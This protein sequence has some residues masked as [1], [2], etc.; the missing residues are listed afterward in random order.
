MFDERVTRGKR[1]HC[2]KCGARRID[3]QIGLEETPDAYVAKLVEVFREV[4]RILHP[5]GTVWLNLGDSFANDGK[6]GGQ[7]GGLNVSSGAERTRRNT[8]LKPKDLIGIPWSVAF[9]LRADGWWLRQEIIWCLSGGTW[10]Y[11]KTQKGEM[12]MMIGDM[13]RLDPSTVKL[14]NGEK[15][16]QV[17]GWSRSVRNDDELELVLRSGERISCTPNHQWPTTRGLLRAD[18]LMVGDYL[19]SCRLPESSDIHA[20]EAIP[21]E[22]AWFLGMYLAEGSRSGSAI[23]IAGHMREVERIERLRAIAEYYGGSLTYKIHGN[24]LTIRMYGGLLHALVDQYIGGDNAKTKGLKVRCWQHSN[25]WLKSLLA[26]YL[27]GDGHWDESNKRWR[28]GFTRNYNLERDLR[29]MCARLGLSLT[30]KLSTATY[31]GGELPAFRGEIRM[32]VSDHHNNKPRTEIVEIRKAR[33][34]E[35][36]DIGVEDEPHLFALASGILTHNSKKAPMPESVTDRPT[37]AHE[38]VFLLSKQAN[39]FYDAE[40]IREPIARE[41][42][43]NSSAGYHNGTAKQ[44]DERGAGLSRKAF[45]GN[46][47]DKSGANRRSVWSLGPENFA[48]AHFAVMPTKLVEPCILAGTSA[49][50]CCAACGAPWERVVERSKYEPEEVA[51]G[52]RNVDDSRGDKTR[53]LS[54]KADNESVR[55]LGESWQPTCDCGADIV[56]CTVLDCFNGAATVGVVALKHHRNYI[57]IDL[58]ADYLELSEKRL[59]QSQ[60]ML[61]GLF[62]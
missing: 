58:N 56:P 20:P 26:G 21:E 50:G 15:W 13:A 47:S 33:C 14:W 24:H 23:Q 2:L 45:S 34:R 44:Q 5:T 43:G 48:G 54:G 9:A 35:V 51:I 19:Q 55:T 11:A 60:P 38:Q 6:W 46:T 10:V 1:S 29:V 37:K 27:D 41:W 49:K 7:S 8:G 57:G 59:N 42:W 52:I 16:T 31:Q 3:Q 39:Y 22:T 40:A 18:E 28:L 17:L 32:D 36:Y 25:T 4:R 61:E 53:R 30:L 62:A 12:P